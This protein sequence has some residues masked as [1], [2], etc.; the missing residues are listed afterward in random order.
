ML[1]G[2]EN[3][4]WSFATLGMALQ[5]SLPLA[6]D[7][8]I[9]V[10][11]A[12][13]DHTSLALTTWA[14]G[15]LS[16]RPSAELGAALRR[17]MAEVAGGCN[18]QNLT[19]YVSGMAMMGT[20]LADGDLEVIMLCARAGADSPL[21]VPQSSIEARRCTAVNVNSPDCTM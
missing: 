4:L 19:N 15:K 8:H 11:A 14:L 7:A 13:H 16:H 20:P 9:A 1:Q 6:V 5:G 2:L 17:R 10:T 18:P 12:E 3:T 21:E